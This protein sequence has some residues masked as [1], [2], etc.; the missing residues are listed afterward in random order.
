MVDEDPFPIPALSDNYIWVLGIEH[1]RVVIVD[2][3]HADPVFEFLHSRSVTPDAILVTHHHHDHVNGVA[4]L[5]EAYGCTVYGPVNP[6]LKFVDVPCQAGDRV[7]I[8]PLSFEVMEVPGH[9]LDHIAFFKPGER[10]LVFCGDTMFAAGCGR[11]FEGDASMMHSSM[12]KLA[13]LPKETLICCA[14]EYTL[15]NLCFAR[16]VDGNNVQLMQREQHAKRQRMQD[17]PTLPSTLEVELATN[18]FLR[19]EDPAIREGLAA[20]Q[21]GHGASAEETFAALRSWKDSF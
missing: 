2:P 20:A 12:Q 10:P 8:G 16:A 5:K 4:A 6:G 1:S 18:P 15:S 11:L 9:T 21:R 17:L 14:H 19:C 13:A 3:G 7:E